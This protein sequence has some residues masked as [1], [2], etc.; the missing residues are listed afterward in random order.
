M[1]E[2][3]AEA[4]LA[5]CLAALRE[6]DVWTVEVVESWVEDDDGFCVVYRHPHHDGLLGCRVRRDEA[7]DEVG[8]DADASGFEVGKLT[9]WE[10]LGTTERELVADRL[11]VRWLAGDVPADRR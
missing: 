4:A 2:S 5:S 6:L 10:P 1:A 3:W 11:G 9:I 8:L 7:D